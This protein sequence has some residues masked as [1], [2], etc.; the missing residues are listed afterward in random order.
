MKSIITLKRLV[1]QCLLFSILLCAFLPVMC[2]NVNAEPN[3]NNSSVSDNTAPTI[4]SYSISGVSSV[5][6]FSFFAPNS[7]ITISAHDDVAGNLVKIIKETYVSDT[8][9]ST[10]EHDI[11]ISTSSTPD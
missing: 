3:S 8:L 5:G 9:V 1:A 11:D 7:T 2:L 10:T 6:T 4:D